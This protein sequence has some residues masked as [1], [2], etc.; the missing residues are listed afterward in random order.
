MLLITSDTGL[1]RDSTESIIT[2]KRLVY[3]LVL[4]WWSI[5]DDKQKYALFQLDLHLEED[6]YSSR[7][8]SVTLAEITPRKLIA[9]VSTIQ[10]IYILIQYILFL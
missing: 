2:F 4:Y 6:L 5:P 1:W 10:F 7:P 8:S 3:Y 9:T